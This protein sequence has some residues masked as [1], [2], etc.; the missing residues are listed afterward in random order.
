MLFSVVFL[1]VFIVVFASW[2][3]DEKINNLIN[4]TPTNN[5]TK[6]ETTTI[7]PPSNSFWDKLLK[8]FSIKNNWKVIMDDTITK[9][10]IPVINGL[11]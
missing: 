4:V 6:A 10:S 2:N 8:S 1:L 11:K 5:R 3:R 9:D 7:V